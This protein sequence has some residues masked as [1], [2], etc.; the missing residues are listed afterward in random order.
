[1]MVLHTMDILRPTYHNHYQIR[2]YNQPIKNIYQHLK[3]PQHP[4]TNQDL[5]NFAYHL[6]TIIEITT[7]PKTARVREK[8]LNLV[9]KY[10]E[11]RTG[12]RNRVQYGSEIVQ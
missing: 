10:I 2:K 11:Y 8:I 6:S 3:H 1:M 5:S 12:R 4:V 7:D 9:R